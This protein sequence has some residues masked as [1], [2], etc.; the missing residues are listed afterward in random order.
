[1]SRDSLTCPV[2]GYFSWDDSVSSVRY[3]FTKPSFMVLVFFSLRGVFFSLR[4]D[5]YTIVSSS[6]RTFLSLSS[7]P[8][9]WTSVSLFQIQLSHGPEVSSFVISIELGWTR[10][11]SVV[12]SYN[13]V[14]IGRNK[15][16]WQVV[17]TTGGCSNLKRNK[18]D[19]LCLPVRGDIIVTCQYSVFCLLWFI[20]QYPFIFP[21]RGFRTNPPWFTS[22]SFKRELVQSPL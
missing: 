7:N 5:P 3:L 19:R 4:T 9:V 14:Y 10:R 12:S 15:N 13:E 6:P 22:M 2:F 21:L 18:G 8:S 20:L 11:V 16:H 1:M 17:F